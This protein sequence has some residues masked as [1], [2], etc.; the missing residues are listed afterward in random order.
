MG[1]KQLGNDTNDDLDFLASIWIL[2]CN[3]ENSIIT[4]EGLKYRLNPPSHIDLKKLIHSRVELFR[5]RVPEHR[6]NEWKTEKLRGEKLPSFLC[7]L[8]ADERKVKINSIKV[9][10]V[11]RNQL[12]AEV[13][14]ERTSLEILSWGLQH[15]DNMRKSRAEKREGKLKKWTSM[16]L[17]LSSLILAL[18]S[19]GVTGYFQYKNNQTQA[20]NIKSQEKLKYYEGDLKPKQESYS[21]LMTS[22]IEA[23]KV[24]NAGKKTEL[25]P[26]LFEV[27]KYIYRALPYL[28][29]NRQQ[30]WEEYTKIEDLCI[31]A[32]SKKDGDPP[33]VPS[34]SV[35]LKDHQDKLEGIFRNE[36]FSKENEKPNSKP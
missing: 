17:P 19:V 15:I 11:F 14:S 30:V 1:Q 7:A 27:K 22:L 2:S 6:L 8:D 33:M 18:L 21:L 31:K 3:E 24:V 4:Y 23:Q 10:D 12:R 20:E 9:D 16:V 35:Q 36:F 25:E 5:R 32:I 34:F 26:A 13:G 29:N 28:I